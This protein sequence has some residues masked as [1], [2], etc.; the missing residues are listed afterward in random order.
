MHSLDYSPILLLVLYIILK[1][2]FPSRK[3]GHITAFSILYKFQIKDSIRTACYG[4][5]GS[6]YLK[7]VSLHNN[8]RSSNLLPNSAKLLLPL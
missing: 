8:S 4:N 2:F 5:K 3:C 6:T 7:T 1:N